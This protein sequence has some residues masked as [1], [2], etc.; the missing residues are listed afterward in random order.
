MKRIPVRSSVLRS[1]GYNRSTSTLEI[2]FMTGLIYRYLRVPETKYDAL[3][4]ASSKGRYFNSIIRDHYSY[5][6]LE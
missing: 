6:P 2:E 1:A 5:A 4:K 3:M